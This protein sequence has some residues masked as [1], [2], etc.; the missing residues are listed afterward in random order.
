[1]S[2]RKPSSDGGNVKLCRQRQE[3]GEKL[4]DISEKTGSLRGRRRTGSGRHSDNDV[5]SGYGKSSVVVRSQHQ[6]NN[7]QSLVSINT[8]SGGRSN[9]GRIRRRSA[10]PGSYSSKL[11]AEINNR[12][13]Q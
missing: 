10:P 9:S 7:T 13:M 8:S 2:S 4:G 3:S 1:M 5:S 11:E 12:N 6:G